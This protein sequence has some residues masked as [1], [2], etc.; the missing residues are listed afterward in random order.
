MTAWRVHVFFPVPQRGSGSSSL[1]SYTRI[2]MGIPIYGRASQQHGHPLCAH[3][4]DARAHAIF[5]GG[6][7]SLINCCS[8]ASTHSATRHAH[9]RTVAADSSAASQTER[10]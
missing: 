3:R 10:S 4:R 1:L 8:Q 6:K 2:M 9:L 5:M 7:H